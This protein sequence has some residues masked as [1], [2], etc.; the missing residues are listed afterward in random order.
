M[1]CSLYVDAG[2]RTC[3]FEQCPGKIQIFIVRW[4]SKE[5]IG[6]RAVAWE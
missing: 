6:I 4:F 3:S 1:V 2:K 5:D